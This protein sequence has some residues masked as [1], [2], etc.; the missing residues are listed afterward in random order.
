[1]VLGS[2]TP[3]LPL[4]LQQ[5]LDCW[6]SLRGL[7]KRARGVW[8][9]LWG[10]PGCGWGEPLKCLVLGACTAWAVP[11]P[12]A[13]AAP[14]IGTFLSLGCA[15]CPL[16]GWG[17]ALCG[18]LVTECQTGLGWEGHYSSSCSTPSI[19]WTPSRLLQ[20]L[21]NLPG[22][23]SRDG[24]STILWE[25]CARAS[26][27]PA[28]CLLPG[29]SELLLQFPPL[30][31]GHGDLFSSLSKRTLHPLTS[32]VA[33]KFPSPQVWDV[34]VSLSQL[35]EQLLSCPE[36]L[37]WGSFSWK[38]PSGEA[39]DF[40]A[41]KSVP[42]PL[43]LGHRAPVLGDKGCGLPR[44]RP[45]PGSRKQPGV[46]QPCCAETAKLLLAGCYRAGAGSPWQS[47]FHL[48]PQTL[49]PRDPLQVWVFPPKGSASKAPVRGQSV[50]NAWWQR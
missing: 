26:F 48:P 18:A 47:R 38:I 12:G 17:C 19:P 35:H 1:M 40:P 24:E 2:S 31:R 7:W 25:T 29:H 33:P 20:A 32:P 16:Q 34:D 10:S 14:G 44:C 21:S 50:R 28:V 15:P 6:K 36:Q 8:C 9:H 42:G 5:R 49:L 11:P 4:G 46:T 27:S 43:A 30:F 45:G 41:P 37:C 13:P 3:V 23:T 22:N 39:K